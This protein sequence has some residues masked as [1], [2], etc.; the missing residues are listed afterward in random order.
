MSEEFLSRPCAFSRYCLVELHELLEQYEED[1]DDELGKSQLFA[2]ILEIF[3]QEFAREKRRW[4]VQHALRRPASSA[5]GMGR[6]EAQ[7]SAV[8]NVS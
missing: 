3:E 8:E 7:E 1:V 5:E 2:G 6:D 4:E